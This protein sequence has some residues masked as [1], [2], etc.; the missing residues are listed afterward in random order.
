MASLLA[1]AACLNC[2]EIKSRSTVN[3]KSSNPNFQKVSFP[4]LLLSLT[5]LLANTFPSFVFMFYSHFHR[6]RCFLNA[7]TFFKVHPIVLHFLS[8]SLFDFLLPLASPV[9]S[10]PCGL[11]GGYAVLSHVKVHCM[12]ISRQHAFPLCN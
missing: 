9:I 4:V 12:L 5:L 11:T 6:E 8:P 7:V 1:F 2:I 3:T 10:P